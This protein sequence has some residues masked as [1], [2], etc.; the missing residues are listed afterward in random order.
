M[1]P[2][3]FKVLFRK[4]GTA[5]AIL[6]IALLIA[7]ITSVNCLVNNINSQTTLLMKLTSLGETYL[8]TSKSSTSLSDSEI[9]STII[10]QIKNNSDVK[11]A[12][13]QQ[14]IQATLTTSAGNYT[15]TVRGLDDIRA[16]FNNRQVRVNGS[17]SQKETETNIGIILAKLASINKNDSLTLT[18]NNKASQFTVAGI[19]Q[20]QEQS[21]TEVIMPLIN[22]QKITQNND[23]VS[24]I[25]FSIKDPNQADKIIANI[26]QTLPPNTKITSTQQ[27][28]AFAQD[29]NNQTVVFI[30]I[31][32]IAIYTVVVAA[33]YIIATRA[34]NEAE[35]EL[36]MLRTLGAKKKITVNLIMIY[37]LTLAFVGSIMGLSIGIVGTQAASTFVRWIWGNSQLAPFLEVNQALEILLLAFA[38]SFIGSIYPAIRGGQNI[39]GANPS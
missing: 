23:T 10:N 37:A 38:S 27:I 13:S 5:S 34:V 16:F 22:L 21:D 2:L 20:T 14:I 36:Y 31:W 17:L 1:Q 19:T 6:A 39:A 24:F 9:D 12:T 28:A 29:V 35:Y 25:E 7:L 3:A 4:K 30:N 8:I 26:T 32:S 18:I 33:S 11:Y 15:V